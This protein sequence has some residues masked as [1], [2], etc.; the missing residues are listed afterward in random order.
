MRDRRVRIPLELL[1]PE[2]RLEAVRTVFPADARTIDGWQHWVLDPFGG[3]E[4]S[5]RWLATVFAGTGDRSQ[6]LAKY[7]PEQPRDAPQRGR[8]I[9]IPETLLLPEFRRVTPVAAPTP[10]AR[11]STSPTP[12]PT[13][14]L[15]LVPKPPAGLLEYGADESG[16]YAV[17]RLQRG[18]A[19]YS[20]VVVRFTGQLLAKQVNQTA[21]EI[22]ARSGIDDVTDISVG[23]PVKIPLDLLLPEYLPAD[24]PRRRAWVEERRELRQFLEVVDAANL[25]GVQ[26]VLDAAGQDTGAAAFAHVG[27]YLEVLSYCI[28]PTDLAAATALRTEQGIAN[29]FFRSD[30]CSAV[31]RLRI[32]QQVQVGSIDIAVSEDLVFSQHSKCCSN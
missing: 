10:R 4:E 15:G 1:Q 29:G 7:N 28:E 2:M 3:R 31:D 26:I 17:Y 20:A 32:Q 16:R 24:D 8:P 25:A 21:M 5:W 22:A 12:A 11:A 27:I 6:E 9:V 18:E 14:S 30:E 19:L 13:G 23:Y